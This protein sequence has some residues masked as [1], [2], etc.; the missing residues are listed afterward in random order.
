V[1]MLRV[2]SGSYSPECVEQVFC[3]LRM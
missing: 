3:G 1:G 2:N